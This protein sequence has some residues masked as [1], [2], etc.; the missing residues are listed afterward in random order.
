VS[1]PVIGNGDIRSRSDYIKIIEKTGCDGVM[2]GRAA[3]GRPWIFSLLN[4]INSDNKIYSE[5]S[6]IINIAKRHFNM[7]I[8]Y[9]SNDIVVIN[10][11]K[12]H[13]SYYFRG[14]DG[15]SFWRKKFMKIQ[16]VE[17]IIP[18]LCEM[19]LELLQ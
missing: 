14:F 9:Y 1:I 10:M 11:S 18:I 12:K 19:E 2:I 13:F 4:D 16:S 3:M 17:E 8:N 5:I 6:S 7:L 15:A